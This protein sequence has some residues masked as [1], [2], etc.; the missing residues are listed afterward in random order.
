MTF[1]EEIQA[2]P[3]ECR[4]LFDS[5]DGGWKLCEILP[6]IYLPKDAAYPKHRPWEVC[7]LVFFNRGRFHEAHAIFERLYLQM[8]RYEIETSEHTPKGVPL[9][10]MSECQRG[11]GRAMIA[12][13]LIMLTLIE[14]AVASGGR[15]SPTEHGSYFRAVW[16]FGI[17]HANIEKYALMAHQLYQRDPRLAH[18]RSGYCSSW[19]PI[20]SLVTLPPRKRTYIR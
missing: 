17:P 18:F 11:L 13:R 7:G 9:V 3:S 19:R 6:K 5:P 15:V 20:G 16:I 4:A 14:D 12:R 1:E 2:L 10:W 8:L